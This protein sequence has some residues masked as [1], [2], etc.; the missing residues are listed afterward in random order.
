MVDL[1]YIKEIIVPDIISGYKDKM[2]A[3]FSV[4]DFKDYKPHLDYIYNLLNKNGLS[5]DEVSL[6]CDF[7]GLHINYIRSDKNDWK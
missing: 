7:M 3:G 4:I 6:E 1:D 5:C 2:N